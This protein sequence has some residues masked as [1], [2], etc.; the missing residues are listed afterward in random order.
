MIIAIMIMIILTIIIIVIIIMEIMII[1]IKII[2]IIIK[3][4]STFQPGK[5]YM[6]VNMWSYKRLVN[7]QKGVSWKDIQKIFSDFHPVICFWNFCIDKIK[8]I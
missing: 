1:M 4:N 2:L 6:V 3:I 7:N 8:E 5:F